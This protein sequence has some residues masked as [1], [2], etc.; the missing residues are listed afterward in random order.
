MS[1]QKTFC[2]GRFISID[3]DVSN[4]VILSYHKNGSSFIQKCNLSRSCL[5]PDDLAPDD[6]ILIE[7]NEQYY[8][9]KKS[10]DGRYSMPLVMGIYKYSDI[11]VLKFICETFNEE[12]R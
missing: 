2:L 12:L 10:G 9:K 3:K 7:R 1:Y 11:N 4:N 5:A 8:V 6:L